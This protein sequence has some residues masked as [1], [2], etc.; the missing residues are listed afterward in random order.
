MKPCIVWD[1]CQTLAD[2]KHRLPWILNKPVNW[3]E[4]DKRAM[5]DTPIHHAKLVFN[6]LMAQGIDQIVITGRGERTREAS[7]LWLASYEFA[8][9]AM[10]MRHEDKRFL[11][12]AEMKL[13]LLNQARA[14]GWHPILAF[15][16]EPNTVSMYRRE[17][18]PVFAADDTHWRN[19]DFREVKQHDDVGNIRK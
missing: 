5:H 19:G 15:D 17:G 13:I 10:Y 18:V 14:D 6:A 8:V 1:L 4:F 9:S 16:D 3:D 11:P 7:S 2:T 12:S